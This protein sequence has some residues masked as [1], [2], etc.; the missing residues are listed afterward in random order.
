[1]VAAVR[2]MAYV[3]ETPWHGLGAQ[4]EA[5]ADMDTWL[6]A[7]GMNY[8]VC[9]SRV[10]YGE[11]ASQRVYDDKHVIFR[12]DTKEPLG[13]VGS[14]FKIV[15][16]REVLGF[17]DDLCREQGF[18]LET[19]GT[20]FD[21]A[22]YW[23]LAKTGATTELAGKDRINGYVLLATA[24]D[25][26]MATTGLETT[27]RVVCN[28]TLQLAVGGA[29]SA[30]KVRHS[31]VFNETRMK[32]D[33][34]LLGDHWTAFASSAKRLSERR[35]T[36]REAAN[37]LIAALGD[38]EKKATEQP[39]VVGQVFDRYE[40]TAKGRTL[41]SANGTAWGLVNAA[42]E[43]Y[44]WHHGRSPQTRLASAWFGPGAS[45]KQSVFGAAMAVVD[46]DKGDMTLE[47]LIAKLN[48]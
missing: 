12:G 27:V 39:R 37:V 38:P 48:E 16:P 25:G 4:L 20:L 2:Q 21:G 17:F 28:N 10:R 42:T 5:G 34:G 31:T 32:V 35:L 15:Q 33:M 47:E 43:E 8:S 22:R 1:M 23:A 36:R 29:K 41:E 14:G 13:V 6:A 11:G 30:V 26:S 40:R 24:C 44:D 45:A 46:G 19:A 18:A 9:R 7:S 3:G